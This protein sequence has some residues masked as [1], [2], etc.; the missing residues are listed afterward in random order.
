SPHS[1]Q[2][3]EFQWP[4]PLGGYFR[5]LQWMPYLLGKFIAGLPVPPDPRWQ[6]GN[7]LFSFHLLNVIFHLA[8]ILLVY[9]IACFVFKSRPLG[10]LAS[11]IFAVHPIGPEVVG[12]IAVFG[13]AACAFFMLLSMV[14]FG[15]FYLKGRKVYFAGSI[16]SLILALCSKEAALIAPFMI[17]L[18]FLFL[19]KS[20]RSE[21]IGRPSPWLLSYF[22]IVSLYFTVRNL[23]LPRAAFEF[24]RNPREILVKLAYYLRDLFSPVE[25]Q[26]VK[27][28]VYAHSLLLWVL[29][30][31]VILM[32]LAGY[33]LLRKFRKSRIIYFSLAWIA[34]SLLIPLLIPF[35]PMRR[36]VYFALAGASI[37]MAQVF[38][39]IRVRKLAVF[40]LA[41]FIILEAWTTIGR[42][43]LFQVA[44]ATVRDGLSDLKAE[45]PAVEPGSIICLAGLPGTISNTPSFWA[46]TEA[47]IWYLYKDMNL[48]VLCLSIIYFKEGGPKDSLFEF[49]DDHT[50]IQSMDTTLDE[51]IRV[52][53]ESAGNKDSGWVW[54]DNGKYRFKILGRD[55]F[56]H[57]NKAKFELD[58]QYT[59]GKRI[60]LI[61]VKAGKVKVLRSYI[62]K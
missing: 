23:I 50:F 25:L 21:L 16:I 33:L 38:L 52:P 59:R 53:G 5:P 7:F 28:F 1:W 56:G 15:Q 49:P 31:G 45:L 48:D 30:L 44:G 39:F 11:L 10:A 20:R 32:I 34:L 54:R 42:N 22:L 2:A 24:I 9:I 57:V 62:A 40:L 61:G 12:W 36:H 26:A 13:D 35:S 8:N 4:G 37:L 58:R 41:L 43:H 18:A 6:T 51:S 19:R 60:Y 46:A 27:D 3:F 29:G 14:L 47:K 55:N 17:I